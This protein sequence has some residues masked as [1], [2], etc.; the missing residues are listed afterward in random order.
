TRRVIE[1]VVRLYPPTWLAAGSSLGE[2][3]LDGYALPSGALVLLSPYLTHRH[4]LF[5][6]EPERFDPNRFVPARAAGRH[7]FAYLPFGGGPRR[8]IG[9]SFATLAMQLIVAP[10]VHRYRLALLPRARTG[11]VAGRPLPPDP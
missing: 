9:S 5:W 8:C 3:T 11:P 1:E 10:V 4:P 6:E 2:D 7:P